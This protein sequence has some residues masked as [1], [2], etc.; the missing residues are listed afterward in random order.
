MK[1]KIIPALDDNYMYLV[2]DEFS[3]KA[4]VVDPVEPQKVLKVVN[5]EGV[6]LTSVF[7][8]HHH[9]DHA[10]GN[11]ELVQLKSDITVYGGDVNTAALTKQVKHLDDINIGF[12]HV[13]CLLTPC[14][15]KG[16]VC[17][18]IEDKKKGGPPAVFTGD[19]LFSAGCGKFFEGTPEQMYQ[20]LVKILG[21]LPD[22]TR[23]YCGHEYTANNLLFAAHVEP[24]NKV[25]LDK[26]EWAK[27]KKATKE[28]TVP[29]TISD[30]KTFNPFMRVHE[31]SVQE[32][33]GKQDPVMVMEALRH[34]KNNFSKRI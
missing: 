20:A 15:T 32:H 14:H 19:T 26:L 1:V 9:W 10:G 13:T 24:S 6:E 23:V 11:A 31:A 28:P 4:A 34:E 18:F 27:R 16:H 12:L 25:I 5:D 30:E 7:T 2:I 3:N 33:T 21:S 17:Y 22:E 29:S 8:T